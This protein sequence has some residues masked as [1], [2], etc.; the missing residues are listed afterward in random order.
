MLAKTNTIK[1]I[2]I[3]RYVFYWKYI[4]SLMNFCHHFYCYPNSHPGPVIMTLLFI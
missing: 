2:F 1:E 4:K 3:H